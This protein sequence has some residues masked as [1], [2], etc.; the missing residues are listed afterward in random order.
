M[1]AWCEVGPASNLNLKRKKKRNAHFGGKNDSEERSE[2][3][4]ENL[5]LLYTIYEDWVVGI[6]RAKI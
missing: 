3:E 4:G 1:D 6:R 5:H 2:I